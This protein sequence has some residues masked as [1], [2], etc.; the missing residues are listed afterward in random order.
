MDENEFK[1]HLMH[2]KKRIHALVLLTV[3]IFGPYFVYDNPSELEA[4]IEK[5]F[6]VS[7]TKYSQLY[8]IYCLPN[9]IVPLISGPLIQRIGHSKGLLICSLILIFG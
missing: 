6:T 1:K 3:T 9:I 7:Q 4:R 5:T 8:S 2:S